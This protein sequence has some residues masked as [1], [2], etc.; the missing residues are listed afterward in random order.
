MDKRRGPFKLF[1]RGG[2]NVV[3]LNTARPRPLPE[4]RILRYSSANRGFPAGN[5][6]ANALVIIVGSLVIAASLVV[7]FL[8]FVVLGTLLLIMAA[9]IGVRL[10]WYNRK[11]AKSGY[12]RQPRQDTRHAI[13]GEFTVVDEQRS[14]RDRP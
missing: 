7:G 4:D 14:D 2:Q 6:I 1:A 9:I 8:A 10:W 5:P 11:A 12:A 13:E 3:Q